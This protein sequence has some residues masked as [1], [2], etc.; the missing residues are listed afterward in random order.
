M[1]IYKFRFGDKV[2]FLDEEHGCYTAGTIV[3]VGPIPGSNSEYWWLIH[4][5]M[6]D[7][8]QLGGVYCEEKDIYQYEYYDFIEKIKDRML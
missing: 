7:D 8:W 1:N 2:M 5:G 6:L 3:S 4:P